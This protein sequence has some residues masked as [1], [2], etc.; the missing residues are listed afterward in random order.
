MATA[1]E[2]HTMRRAISL[3]AFGLGTTSPNPP[4][5]C[6]ILDV[7]G[8]IA[9][10]GYHRRKG[11]AH[12]EVLALGAAGERAKG[13]TAVVTLEPCNHHGRTPPCHQ[14]LL[15]AE[16]VRTIVAVMDPTSRGEG[17]VARMR[18]SGMDV[19]TGVLSSE[20][21]LV[22]GPWLTALRT[23]RPRVVWA[24]TLATDGTVGPLETVPERVE[25]LA[26]VDALLDEG[27]FVREAMPNSH[28]HG[29]LRLSSVP[30]PS[31]PHAALDALF[32]AGVR[33][34]LLDARLS[35]AGEFLAEGLVDCVVA[36]LALTGPS[37]QLQ[38]G[39][40]PEL[41][42]LPGGLQ[43]VQ[44]SR[45]REYVRAVGVRESDPAPSG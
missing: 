27:G 17:G 1:I 43:L 29:M 7:N 18:R 12:A 37:F 10:E 35:K 28:G 44:V 36:Y 6:V 33:S 16:I 38:T 20:A 34:V 3:S 23:R 4:V 19:E 5:G 2:L 11:E 39:D 25:L 40:P 15:D 8:R 13:G 32:T 45:F 22:L 21:L 31:G 9:G 41:A 24:Y 30:L 14:A 26:N 42:L